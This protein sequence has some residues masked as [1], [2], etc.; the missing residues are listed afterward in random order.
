MEAPGI[1]WIP[2]FDVYISQ[3]NQLGAAKMIF[4]VDYD[5]NL[6]IDI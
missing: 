6:P 2:L 5:A 3:K 4:F 1:C